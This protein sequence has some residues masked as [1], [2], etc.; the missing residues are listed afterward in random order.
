[1]TDKEMGKAPCLEML[2]ALYTDARTTVEHEVESG[3]TGAFWGKHPAVYSSHTTLNVPGLVS[4]R[5]L[6]STRPG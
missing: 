2:P 6:S 4:P 5:E 3:L 1:M